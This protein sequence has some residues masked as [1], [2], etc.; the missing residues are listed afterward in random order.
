MPAIGQT[1]ETGYNK[2]RARQAEADQ[3][4]MSTTGNGRQFLFLQGPHGP[5]LRQLAAA[6]TG[7]GAQVHRVGFN[8]GD[9]A[10]WGI[11]PGYIPFRGPIDDWPARLARLLDDLN[12]TD[13][14]VYGDARPVHK[15]AIGAARD[16]GLAVHVLEEGYLRPFWVTYERGG[17]NGNSP[18][19]L[20]SVAE[21]RA[22]LGTRPE[23]HVEAPDHWGALRSHILFGALYHFCILV[24]N[25]PY[26]R[27]R[28]HRALSV[29]QEFRLHLRKLLTLPWETARRIAATARIRRGG[30][31]YHLVLLQLEHDANFLAF[32]PFSSQAQFIE[33]VIAGFARGA[34]AHHH[35]VF[36]AHP[37]E[38]R[39]IPLRRIIAAQTRAHGLD[40]RVHFVGGGKLGALLDHASSAVTVNSTAA[41]QALW[42]GLPLRAFGHSVYDKPEFVSALPL[43]RFFARPAAPDIPAYRDYRRFLLATSQIPGS[44]YAARGRRQVVRRLVDA[45]LDERDP[46]DLPAA[47][48]DHAAGP[49]HLSR[50]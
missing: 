35:L 34:P 38:D 19:L 40:R 25:H 20:M 36:K 43:F 4:R 16:R 1:L 50:V 3:A 39:R 2:I 27:M 32:S 45:L 31:A 9:R 14:L 11:R 15:A 28:R 26:R 33:R 37:L 24:A 10:F 48:N 18:L 7:A 13:I 42:R 22:R 6:L 47:A 30:F 41:Q 46:Y 21:I 17:S 8:A 5:F 49:Q 29:A 12:I 44:Y 23:T